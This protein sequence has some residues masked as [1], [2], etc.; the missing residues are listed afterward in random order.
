[1][2]KEELD[3][4]LRT[5]GIDLKEACTL[6]YNYTGAV[7]SARDVKKVFERTGYLSAPMTAVFVF[8]FKEVPEK[9]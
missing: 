1:M 2:K 5:R 6:I 3:K 9:G 4:F 8:L 7:I